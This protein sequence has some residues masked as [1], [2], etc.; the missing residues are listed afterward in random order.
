[1]ALENLGSIALERGAL[2]EARD[3]FTRALASD[4]ASAQAHNGLG[5]VAMKAGDRRAAIDH[6]RQSVARD[7][8]NFYALYNVAIALVDEGQPADARPYLERFA[9]TAPPAFMLPISAACR[10]FRPNGPEQ[11]AGRLPCARLRSACFADS[12]PPPLP[13]LR[14]IDAPILTTGRCPMKPAWL[15]A[16]LMVAPLATGP[17]AQEPD[18]QV[19][20]PTPPVFKSGVEVTLRRAGSR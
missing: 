10:R 16:L 5:V 15:V 13:V 12:R 2:T 17:S 8:M 7:P 20:S 14:W 6:W 18:R 4:P 11:L 9:R 19:I 1:M 3:Y